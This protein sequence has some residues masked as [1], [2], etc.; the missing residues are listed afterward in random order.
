MDSAKFNKLLNE[1][2]FLLQDIAKKYDYCEELLIM[3]T[4][5]YICFYMDFGKASDLPLY[6][7]LNKVR[8][9]YGTGTTDEVAVSN[10]LG[11]IP[12]GS[13]AVTLF[14]PNFDVFKNA[15]LKQKPQTII[16]GTHVGDFLAT[17]VLKLE[18]LS[19]EVRHALMGYFNTNKLLDPDTYYMRSGLNESYYT[20]NKEGKNPISAKHEGNTLDEITNTYITERLVNRIMS[21]QKYHHMDSKFKNYLSTLK[22]RQEDGIYRPIGYYSEV[23]LFAPLLQ[24]QTFIDLVNQHQFDGE[25]DIIKDL[26][27][28]HT[29]LCDYS[30]FCSLL[31]TVYEGNGKYPNEANN[32]N[33]EFVQE[34]IQNIQKVKSIV[35]DLNQH[36][37]SH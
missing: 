22:T 27:N 1:K 14:T 33:I 25:I 28:N 12:K 4:F 21:F 20:R 5:M 3:I 11:H 19:H 9:I 30:S 37:S 13:A 24:N 16:L 6:D 31:D 34:H 23:R 7:L 36:L 35:L 2:Y 10:G 8:I 15:S 29:D 32:Q 17:P 26:I 18:M